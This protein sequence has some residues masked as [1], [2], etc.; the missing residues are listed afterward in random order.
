[1][2]R[3][4]KRL[5]NLE[6]ETTAVLRPVGRVSSSRKRRALR[7]RL[8]RRLILFFSI[9]GSISYLANQLKNHYYPSGPVSR[10]PV[11]DQRAIQNQKNQIAVDAYTAGELDKAADLFKVLV[12]EQPNRPEFHINLGMTFFKAHD[13]ESA[14]KEFKVATILDKNNSVALNNLGMV[15]LQTKQFDLAEQSFL[16]AAELNPL[17]A[18][19]QFNLATYY[20]KVGKLNLAIVTY[21]KFI[22]HSSA[23]PNIIEQVKRRLPRLNT[24]STQLERNEGGS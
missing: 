21:Q 23:Q 14:E 22:A 24:L 20:E 1:M 15:A 7:I 10:G 8:L 12:L 17:S 5:E 3:I 6:N 16:K 11:V 9:V 4:L 19:I 13:F 2:S 18:D